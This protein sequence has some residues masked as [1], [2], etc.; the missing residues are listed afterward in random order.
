MKR[1]RAGGILLN[2][3]VCRGKKSLRRERGGTGRR[4]RFRSLCPSGRGGSTPLARNSLQG[5]PRAIPQGPSFRIGPPYLLS[6]ID[7]RASSRAGHCR[8]QTLCA[9]RLPSIRNRRMNCP[10]VQDSCLQITAQISSRVCCAASVKPLTRTVTCPVQQCQPCAHSGRSCGCGFGPPVD[11]DLEDTVSD[12][13]LW[14]RSAAP[15]R[16][17]R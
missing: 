17:E 8:Q 12:R 11:R 14:G 7:E 13:R 5:E 6:A 1:P 15:L 2:W 10:G 3:S 16:R 9:D 4:A